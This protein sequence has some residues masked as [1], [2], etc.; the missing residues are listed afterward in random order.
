MKVA[1]NKWDISVQRYWNATL[2]G[3]DCNR[4]L[5]YCTQILADIRAVV[6]LEKCGG[7]ECNSFVKR[8]ADVLKPLG[9]V[10]RETRKVRMLTVEERRVL[11]TACG[12]FGAAW[13]VSYPLRAKLNPKGHIAEHHVWKYAEMY[14]TGGFFGEDGAKAIHVSDSACRRIVR[15]MRNPEARHKAPIPTPHRWIGLRI[16]G[17]RSSRFRPISP[18]EPWQQSKPPCLQCPRAAIK[19]L[20]LLLLLRRRRRQSVLFSSF[21]QWRWWQRWRKKTTNNNSNNNNNNNNNNKT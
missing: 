8:H 3:P 2:V 14:G 15:Q 10:L 16:H 5:K 17:A 7:A 21:L 4:F 13:R 9:V 20:L 12:E 18:T 19:G 1:L 6:V 11:K